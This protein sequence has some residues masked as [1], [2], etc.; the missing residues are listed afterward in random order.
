MSVLTSNS[1]V[2]VKLIGIGGT[3]QMG[4]WLFDIKQDKNRF[5]VEFIP[6]RLA[7]ARVNMLPKTD[8]PVP[9]SVRK[10]FADFILKSHHEIPVQRHRAVRKTSPETHIQ[11]L[12][13]II[14]NQEIMPLDNLQEEVRAEIKRYFKHPHFIQPIKGKENRYWFRSPAMGR[15]Y[16]T[17]CPPN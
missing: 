1:E 5:V 8:F 11:A 7:Y 9:D 15:F 4:I 14:L 13:N 16:V 3:G 10:E 17:Q 12:A 2:E 6:E